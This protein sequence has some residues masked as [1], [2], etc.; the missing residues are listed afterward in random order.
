[1]ERWLL[2]V[3]EYPNFISFDDNTC[4]NG[5]TI[6]HFAFGMIFGLSSLVIGYWSILFSFV[7]SIVYEVI[8]N[9]GWFQ[10]IDNMWNS[11]FDIFLTT[12]GT[13]LTFILLTSNT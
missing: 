2:S 5:W 11:I 4:V 3:K 6:F 1:M 12:C 8:E 7:L 13:L 9:S 10:H